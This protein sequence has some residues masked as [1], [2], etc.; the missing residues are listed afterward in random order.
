MWTTF[1]KRFLDA[2][3]SGRLGY[4]PIAAFERRRLFER[5]LI[6]SLDPSITVYAREGS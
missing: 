2:L 5:E 6:T 3:E 4:R 1:K